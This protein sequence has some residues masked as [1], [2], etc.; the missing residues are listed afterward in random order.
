[1]KDRKGADFLCGCR[2]CCQ[3]RRGLRSCCRGEWNC[4]KK[5]CRVGERKLIKDCV[6]V[7]W[8]IP[9]KESQTVFQATNQDYLLA[10]GFVSFESGS[11]FIMVRFFEGGVEVGTPIVVFENSSVAFSLTYFDQI[12]V[13]CRN[14]G[15]APTEACEGEL[16]LNIRVPA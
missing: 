2:N 15:T 5:K 14:T 1:M 10:S 4:N 6:C 11:E 9:S 7:E 12:T 8:S 3:A 16:C 13:E